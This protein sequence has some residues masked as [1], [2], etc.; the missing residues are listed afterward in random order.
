MYGSDRPIEGLSRVEVDGDTVHL[1]DRILLAFDRG[2]ASVM[3]ARDAELL[4][5]LLLER[6]SA[7][8]VVPCVPVDDG[9]VDRALELGF[10]AALTRAKRY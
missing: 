3:E 5:S 2:E 4:I 10:D 1:G 7:D 9:L 6:E 8:L